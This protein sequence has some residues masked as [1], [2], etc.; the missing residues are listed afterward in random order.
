M[1]T[2]NL[3]AGETVPAL[4]IGT[5][6]M[7]EQRAARAEELATLKLALDLGVRLIDTAEMYGEGL[8]EELVG[9]ALE[10]RRDEAFI[11]SKVYPHNADRR[12]CVAACERS[13]KRLRTDRLD[14]Y[15]L[16][17]RGQVPLAE[18]LEAFMAL[19]AA[20]KIRHFGVSNFD[21][22]DMQELAGLP[23]GVEVQTDQVLY[24]PMQRGAEWELLPW[25][26][27]RGIAAMAYSP[28]DEGRL[29]RHPGF[30]A[31]AKD[32]GMTPARLA[33][34]WLLSN[35]RIIAIPKTSQRARLKESAAALE[36]GLTSEE[37]AA[38]DKLFPAP[39]RKTALRM[40]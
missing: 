33:L 10:G 12:G 14:L 22:A 21:S 38:V 6:R 20:G 25:L 23:G 34:A 8:A 29:L 24:N 7:G 36:R 4:G 30:A 1:H 3:P 26:R 19:R 28:L 35:D 31:L 32:I 40:Y 18:T 15:L 13:L 37:L 5:W 16:H 11:V 17:W 2:V 39:R 27:E 9:E